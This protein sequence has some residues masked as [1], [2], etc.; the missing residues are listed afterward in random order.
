M[1]MLWGRLEDFT[2]AVEAG[3]RTNGYT[4]NIFKLNQ[5]IIFFDTTDTKKCQK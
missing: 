2:L 5:K 3:R 4:G 1:N